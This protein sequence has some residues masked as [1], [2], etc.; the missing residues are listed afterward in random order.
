N[1]EVA[2]GDG[3]ALAYRARAEVQDMEFIQF[4][5]TALRLP[6]VPIFLISE[7]V[8]G[9]GGILRNAT[10]ERFMPSYHEKA[11]LAPRDI[12]AR[13]IVSEMKRTETDRVYLDITHLDASRITARFPQ[14]YRHCL[15][16]GVDLTKEPVPVS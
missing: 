4:H 14:I 5:P 3:I 6:G 15:E 7:A 8:R 2:T 16:H 1:P 12:V 11:E 13:A 9:E 10:G